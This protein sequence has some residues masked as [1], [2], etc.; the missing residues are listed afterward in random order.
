MKKIQTVLSMTVALSESI[1][2]PGKGWEKVDC[3]FGG[4]FDHLSAEVRICFQASKLSQG[5]AWDVHGNA[6]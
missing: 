6:A 2:V 1:F 4:W 3:F 5:S